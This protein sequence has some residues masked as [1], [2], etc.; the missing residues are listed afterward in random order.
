MAERILQL[1]GDPDL[2]QRLGRAGRAYVVGNHTWTR[3]AATI[4]EVYGRLA[5]TSKGAPVTAQP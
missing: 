4:L 2:R 1:A 3:N 5:A